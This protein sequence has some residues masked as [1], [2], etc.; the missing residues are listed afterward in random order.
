HA[1]IAMNMKE[2]STVYEAFAGINGSGY[3]GCL[4]AGT[5][6]ETSFD[7]YRGPAFV[8]LDARIGKTLT[9]H[10][11]YNVNLF[12][13]GFDLTNRANF[14]PSIQGKVSD[15]ST[16]P[17][18]STFLQPFDFITPNSTVIPRSFTGEFG[19]RFSF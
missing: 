17:S 18:A 10:D 5:C 4:A 15:F 19:G 3:K 9:F 2:S 12:F 13:Q 16:D 14:G 7:T 11:K 8:E 1:V 6:R